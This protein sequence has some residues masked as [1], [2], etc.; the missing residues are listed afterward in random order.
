LRAI[1]IACVM[2]Y[3]AFGTPGFQP[4][5]GLWVWFRYLGELGVRVFFVISGWLI[6]SLLLRELTKTGTI[7]LRRFY[8]RRAMR[9][10]PAFYAFLAFVALLQALGAVGLHPGDLARAATYTMN[11]QRDPSWWLV[12]CWSLAVEEQFY[13]LWPAMLVLVGARRGFVIAGL[14]VLGGPVIRAVAWKAFPNDREII[15]VTGF[16]TIGDTIAAGCVLAGMRGWL[17]ASARYQRF[18]RSPAAILAPAGL[19]LG[20]LLHVL[21]PYARVTVAPTMINVSI[22]LCVD[23]CLRNPAGVIVRFFESRPLVIVGMGSYSLYLWQEPFLNKGS[24]WGVVG[25]FPI[26]VALAGLAAAASYFL[27]ERPVLRWRERLETAWRAA[28][29]TE[30]AARGR[31]TVGSASASWT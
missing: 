15:G 7:S 16:G 6:T 4:S 28:R 13:L 2:A 27:V 25:S 8:A 22:A 19:V 9:L 11:Y 20:Y 29:P 1:S 14:F 31:D 21:V 12:H 18:M 24:G 26:N 3:H 30:S 10:F 23:H 5:K 17:D